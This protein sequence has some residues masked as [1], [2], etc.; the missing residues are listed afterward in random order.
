M[1][2]YAG[3]M[4]RL[5]VATAAAA[6]LTAAALLDRAWW[7]RHVVVPACYLP[8]AEWK[9]PA[10]RIGLALCGVALSI[11][12]LKIRR[13]RADVIAA[14]ALALPASEIALRLLERPESKSPHPRL[15]SLL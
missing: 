15:E 8:P 9:L 11:V 10:V 1:A 13:V 2:C 7:I 14:I 4:L 3:A 5:A 6:L 12:A